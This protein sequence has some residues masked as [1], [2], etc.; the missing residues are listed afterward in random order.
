VTQPEAREQSPLGRNL[1]IVVVEEDADHVRARMVIDERHK[2]PLGAI[3][4]ARSY[5]WPTTPPRA[6]PTEPTRTE[7]THLSVAIGCTVFSRTK[8]EAWWR[9]S[10]VVHK[11]A[12]LQSSALV[13]GEQGRVSPVDDAYSG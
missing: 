6:W 8:R 1:G 12:A 11:A 5:R 4:A 9:P 7:P 2:N 3:T 10:H 13:T